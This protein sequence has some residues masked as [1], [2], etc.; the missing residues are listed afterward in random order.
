MLQLDVDQMATVFMF[1]VLV[2]FVVVVGLVV[3]TWRN[4]R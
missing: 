4:R 1:F 3:S 2:V